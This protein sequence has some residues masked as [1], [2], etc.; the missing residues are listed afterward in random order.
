MIRFK[1]PLSGETLVDDLVKGPVT[2]QN[3]ELDDLVILRSDGVPTYNL[4]VVVDD[5]DMGITHVIR[6]D[7]HLNNAA[8]QSLIYQA[9]DFTSAGLRAPAA[10]P[11]PRRR[12]T[13]KA[14]WCAGGGRVRRD[15]IPARGHAQLPR[16]P[17]LGTRR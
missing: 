10:D 7:D 1:G 3:K 2:F 17:R 11:R 15:G 12:E 16:A 14:P 6:G 9:L 4:A 5:H 13:L 8:R